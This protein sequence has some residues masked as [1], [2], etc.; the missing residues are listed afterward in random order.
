MWVYCTLE[1]SEST[2]SDPTLLRHAHQNVTTTLCVVHFLPTHIPRYSK[3]LQRMSKAIL[4]SMRCIVYAMCIKSKSSQ[5]N[6]AVLYNTSPHCM[7]VLVSFG[8]VPHTFLSHIHP[9]AALLRHITQSLRIYSWN[10]QL[11]RI[12]HNTYTAVTYMQIYA[13]RSTINLNSRKLI[14]QEW[15]R[16]SAGISACKAFERCFKL[17]S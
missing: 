6:S 9:Q 10:L 15:M 8:I 7:C 17:R 1:A 5:R 4:I 14:V 3:S 13:N 11:R 16:C 2:S 12:K